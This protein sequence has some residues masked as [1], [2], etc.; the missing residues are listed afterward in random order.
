MPVACFSGSKCPNNIFAGYAAYY[1]VVIRNIGII[2]K[3]KELVVSNLPV[4][5]QS[6]DN[7][8]NA[9]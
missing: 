6:N 3:I 4:Y 9:D 7:H 5:G 2:V 1:M 8:C